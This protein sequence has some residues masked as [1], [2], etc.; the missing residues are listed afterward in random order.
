MAA[1][2]KRYFVF[3]SYVG[4][5][6]MGGQIDCLDFDLRNEELSFQ[7]I[8]GGKPI[9]FTQVRDDITPVF[10]A[11]DKNVS[12][13]LS[14]SAISSTGTGDLSGLSIVNAEAILQIKDGPILIYLTGWEDED[15]DAAESSTS[16]L[17]IN[18]LLDN[19]RGLYLDVVK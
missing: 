1:T 9:A 5:E 7:K 4:H 16:G 6:F 3:E 12:V 13:I 11:S 8:T 14:G 19:S 15:C 10:H 18:D 2:D 17:T